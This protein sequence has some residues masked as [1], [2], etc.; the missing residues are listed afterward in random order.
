MPDIKP[1]DVARK[2]EQLKQRFREK[3]STELDQLQMAV[4]RIRS[5]TGMADNVS[6]VYQS[7]HRL[8][9]S[10]GTF[11]YT[12]L[13]EEARQLELALKPLFDKSP[14]GSEETGITGDAQQLL[15]TEFLSRITSLRLLLQ[16]PGQGS[17]SVADPLPQPIKPGFARQSVVQII[18]SDPS[19]AGELASGLALHGFETVVC[20]SSG[21]SKHTPVPDLSAV[22]IRATQVLD[23][24]LRLDTLGD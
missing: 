21:E 20:S 11:G 8:A 3:T 7:L 10:A 19:R 16:H 24:K 5:G 18:D 13:G 9:G 15:T 6:S 1:P 17:E 23:D 2:L 14:D 12:T 22:V 4:E